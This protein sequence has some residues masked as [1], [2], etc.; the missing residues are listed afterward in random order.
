MKVATLFLT[1]LATFAIS[2]PTPSNAEVLSQRAIYERCFAKLARTT[3]AIDDPYIS[4]I[5]A[6]TL[7]GPEACKAVLELAQLNP[8]NGRLSTFAASAAK[9]LLAK[10]VLASMH[11]F[12]NS[13][14]TLKEYNSAT[15]DCAS[16]LSNGLIDPQTPALLVT[17]ALFNSNFNYASLVLSS[18]VPKAIREVADPD[19][20]IYG[21]DKNKAGADFTSLPTGFEFVGNGALLGIGTWA[22]LQIPTLTARPVITG[23]TPTVQNFNVRRSQGGGILGSQAYLLNNFGENATVPPDVEKMARHWSKYVFTDL[24]C[25]ELPVL[26]TGDADS[27][28]NTA[29]TAL[30]F[31]R[32]AGCVQC[33]ASMDQLEGVVRKQRLFRSGIC[34]EVQVIYGSEHLLAQAPTLAM[35]TAWPAMVDANYRKHPPYGKLFYRDYNNALHNVAVN[36]LAE[37]GTQISTLNDMYVCAAKRYYQYFT[38]IDVSLEPLNAAGVAALPADQRFYRNRVVSLGMKLKN[39]G[40]TDFNK[41]A[42]KLIQAIFDLPEYRDRDFQLTLKSQGAP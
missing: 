37:L 22:S 40:A 25:R 28:V 33:H 6:G 3:P 15:N 23:D 4:Q 5:T 30:A 34:S 31:R 8:A 13:W 7:T 36:S 21:F 14:F 42:S 41:D 38:G 18:D 32:Q 27:F 17:R 19:R 24:F 26:N 2:L 39:A 20:S 10:K 1:G 35:S 12:H 16:D 9:A 11:A 29:T